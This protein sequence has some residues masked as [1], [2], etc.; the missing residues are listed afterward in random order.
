MKFTKRMKLSLAGRLYIY[1]SIVIVFSLLS[2][3]VF[4][5]VKSASA[6][7]RQAEAYVSQII[8]NA[9]YQTDLY[10]QTYERASTSILSSGDVKQLMDMDPADNYLFFELSTQIKRYSYQPAF[11]LYPQIQ[12]IYVINDDGKTVIDDNSSLTQLVGFQ[13]KEQLDYVKA[14]TPDNG[15]I[16]FLTGSLR[17]RGDGNTVTVARKIRGYS[18]YEPRGI[19]AIE[20]R[21]EELAN[22][23]NKV[24]LGSSGFFFILDAEGGIRYEPG[25]EVTPE[26]LGSGLVSRITGETAHSEV[27]EWKG[28]PY[29]FVSRKSPYTGWSLAVAIPVDELRKP[30]STIRVTIGIVGLLTLLIAMLVAIRF[31]RSIAKPIQVLKEGMRETERG[32]WIR[33]ADPKREDEIGGLVHSYNVMVARLSSMIEKVYE[34]ELAHQKTELALREKDLERQRA[35]FQALQLQINPHFLYNTL[36]TINSYAIVQDSEEISEVVEALA[37]MLRYSIQTNLEEITVANELNHVRNF[38]IIHEHRLGRPFEID[39][40][41]PP[42]LLLEYMVRLTLQPVVENAFQHAFPQGIEDHHRIR[43]DAK[44]E[45]DRFIVIVEDNGSGMSPERLAELREKLERN[46]LAHHGDNQIAGS[47]SMYHR[48]GIGLINVHRRIQLVFGDRYGMEVDSTEGVGTQIRLV[49]PKM[50]KKRR[51]SGA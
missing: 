43:I 13:P 7:D 10:L 5:Y 6:I 37:F 12:L 32:N 45:D 3:G 23:W 35:E 47:T 21:A 26:L 18:T 48:G 49:M 1:F 41:I 28:K 15:E 34:A 30:I 29:L 42:S 50:E 2:V 46:Q 44:V 17:S 11:I 24:D 4:S 51:V 31:G 9:S 38:M 8:D 20:M 39:V 25:A 14:H 33:I 36:Q 27:A 22:I 19:L 40:I 16:A